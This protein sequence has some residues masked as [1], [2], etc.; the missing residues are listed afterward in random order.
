MITRKKLILLLANFCGTIWRLFPSRLSR[1][2]IFGLL[3][4]SSRQK[5]TNKALIELFWIEDKLNLVINERALAYGENE[6]PKHTLIPYH[7]FFIEHIEDGENIIDIGCG[8]GAVARS[9]AMAKPK[10]L[11]LGIDNDFTR[12]TQ[13]INSKNPEN[14]SFL[15]ADI[16]KSMALPD[17]KWDTVVLSN[18]LEHLENRIQSLKDIATVTKAD[19]YLIRVPA[20]ERG[21]KIALRKKLGINYFQDD[22]HKIEHTL[23]EFKSEIFQSGL[24][25]KS[26]DLIW[27]EIWAVCAI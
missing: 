4:I 13:A 21:W 9:I 6:H 11:V 19:K 3:V 2:F 27:G 8:Y 20:F 1:Y 18:V 25:L 10:S 16:K 22:D 24:Q 23:A 5:F 17:I 7:N 26:I 12:F 15:L 14:L